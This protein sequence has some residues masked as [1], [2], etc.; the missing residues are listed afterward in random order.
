MHFRPKDHNHTVVTL[1]INYQPEG[2]MEK[3][4]AALGWFSS[5]VESDLRRFKEFVQERL[6][7]TGAW[8][9]EI[10]GGKERTPGSSGTGGSNLP[11]GTT[12]NIESPGGGSTVQR[13]KDQGTPKNK[14]KN[15]PGS[16]SSRSGSI[17]IDPEDMDDDLNA[18]TPKGRR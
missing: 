2:A 10:H 13:R 11:P 16:S 9:G 17:R 14:D 15:T 18:G 7:E 4:G 5:K 12:R 1:R 3:L 8:R 6:T